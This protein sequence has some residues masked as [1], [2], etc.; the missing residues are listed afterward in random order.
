M[1]SRDRQESGRTVVISQP[2]YFPWLGLF[3][4]LR[5]ADVFI[6]YDDVQLARGFY[7]RV[8]VKTPQGTS[9]I[10]VPLKNKHRDSKIN[11]CR[12]SYESDW[13][14]QH[15]AVLSSSYRKTPFLSDAIAIFDEVTGRRPELLSELGIGS[16]MSIA[17]YLG[18][19]HETT[20]LTS[21]DLGIAGSSSQRLLD[22][23]IAQNAQV[24]LTG[25]G[26]LNYLDH[27]LF[28]SR[29]VEVR[30]IKY[31]FAEYPQVFGEFTPYV[32]ALDAIAHLGRSA[33]DVFESS[34]LN[35]RNAVEQSGELRPRV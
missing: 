28:E 13:V 32:T 22:I 6:H 18:L 3:E 24:Y 10:T 9:M 19:T 21:S 26:A 4:Q 8:Q 16:I 15:R 7:N 33:V 31:R 30:Y 25:H 29:D 34:T 14:S 20:F 12:I 17:D 23:S 1:V 27:E 11:E 35:W 5:T 2:M